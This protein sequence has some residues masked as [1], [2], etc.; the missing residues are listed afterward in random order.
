[1]ARKLGVDPEQVIFRFAMQVGMIPLTGTTNEQHMK[2]DLSA[3]RI[4]LS[5]DEVSFIESVAG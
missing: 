1:M 2:Q 5:D 4:A 3:Y